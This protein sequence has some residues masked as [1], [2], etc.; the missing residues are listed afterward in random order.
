MCDLR[1][2]AMS[3]SILNHWKYL[4]KYFK[5]WYYSCVGGGDETIGVC[6]C[7]CVCVWPEGG[8]DE[9]VGK[10]ILP[11]R[12]GKA[13]GCHFFFWARQMLWMNMKKRI[14]HTNR[15]LRLCVIHTYISTSIC[16]TYIHIYVYVSHIHIYVYMSLYVSLCMQLSIHVSRLTHVSS[17]S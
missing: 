10:P 1:A 12:E 3:K 9:A 14:W 7:V 2:V 11:V 17:S 4:L 8:G 6:V 5:F 16:H 15:E 13:I